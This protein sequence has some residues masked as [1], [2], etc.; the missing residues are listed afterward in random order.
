MNVRLYLYTLEPNELTSGTT[1]KGSDFDFCGPEC[2]AWK[3]LRI[4]TK[5]QAD[6][7]ATGVN[8]ENRNE[9]GMTPVIYLKSRRT[10]FNLSECF[11]GNDSRNLPNE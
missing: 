11:S 10:E 7:A 1:K 5:A 3:N 6:S 4:T 9:K 8:V 2:M